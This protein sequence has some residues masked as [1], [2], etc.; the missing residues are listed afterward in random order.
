MRRI[1][2]CIDGSERQ[3]GVLEAASGL[4]RR[5]GARLLLFQSVGL[6][7]GMP[8]DAWRLSPNELVQALEV[9]A[10]KNL[11]ACEASLDASLRGGTRVVIGVPW[12][13]ICRA[14]RDEDVD[15]VLLG[16]HGYDALDRVVGTTAAK[17]VNHADRAVMVVR[18][19]ERLA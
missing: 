12:E 5:T 1:L 2:V 9:A 18:A 13:S 15:L 14:A 4:A 10:Q 6:P 7:R 3:P 19:H 8:V 17:V 11:A 16:S